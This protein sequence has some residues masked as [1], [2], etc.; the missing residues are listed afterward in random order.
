[1]TNRSL[2]QE[3]DFVD[4]EGLVE[5]GDRAEARRVTTGLRAPEGGD[6]D[7]GRERLC[8]AQALEYFEPGQPGPNDIRDHEIDT[9]I[10]RWL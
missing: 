10:F 7:K 5:N 2:D 9:D 3:E 1:M 8:A 6:Y 4:L